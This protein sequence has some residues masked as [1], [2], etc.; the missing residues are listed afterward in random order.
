ML[1]ALGS[2]VALAG[3]HRSTPPN[4]LLYVVD[5]LRFDGVHCNGNDGVQTPAMDR[6]AH[7]GVRFTRAYANASWT[8]ASMGS[9]LSGEYPSTHGAVGRADGLR[10]GIVTLPARLHALGYRTAAIIANPNIGST[11]GFASGFDE[12]I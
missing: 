5:T 10:E 9:L 7:D 4:I 1:A 11:F 2:C 8:R 3:C 6:L 12:F